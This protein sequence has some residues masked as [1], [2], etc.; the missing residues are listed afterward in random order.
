MKALTGRQ[1]QILAFLKSFAGA[2]GY[3][4]TRIEIARRFGFRSP[5][6]AQE[7]LAAIERKGHI[8]LV[9]GCARGIKFQERL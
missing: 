7:H 5:N 8:A 2:N 6:A 3:P 1:A 9:P 4:P